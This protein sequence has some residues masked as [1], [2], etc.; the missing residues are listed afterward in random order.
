ML[1]FGNDC[2]NA[3]QGVT[4][5]QEIGLVTA[6]VVKRTRIVV[7]CQVCDFACGVTILQHHSSKAFV[8]WFGAG[9]AGWM[10]M[11]IRFATWCAGKSDMR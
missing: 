9:D 10:W 8:P 1:A 6:R 7:R 3:V 5:V 2:V 11:T 4:R